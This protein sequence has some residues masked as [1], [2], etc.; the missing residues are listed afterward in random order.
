[1]VETWYELGKRYGI[2]LAVLADIHARRVEETLSLVEQNKPDIILIPGDLVDGTT[3]EK[4]KK[5]SNFVEEAITNLNR[6]AQIAPTY[7]SLGNHEKQ[8][9]ETEIKELHRSKAVVVDNRYVNVSSD[10]YI[11]GISSGR[12][13]HD[14]R[15]SQKPDISFIPEFEKVSGFKILLSHHP[16]YYVPFLKDKDIDLIISGHAH[17]GQIRI[18]NQGLFAPGQG[19]F[20]K[21]TSGIHDGKL[22]VSRGISGTELF[23]RINN[24]PE[25]VCIKI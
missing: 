19:L 9:I 14:K 17:G 13:Y 10:L 23:P 16:E 3:I 5:H 4:C 20:P 7:Y 11:G 12:N 18:G 25:I 6:I 8:M 21:Y 1:M 24:K 22:V 15:A 2:T